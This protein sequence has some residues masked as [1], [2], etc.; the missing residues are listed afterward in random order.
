MLAPMALA[1]RL[2]V[3]TI[4]ARDVERLRRFYQDLGWRSP[5]SSDPDFARFETGGAVLTLYRMGALAEEA[6]QAEPPPGTFGGINCAVNV[7][8]PEEVDA[9]MEVVRRAGG[10][11]VAEPVTRHWGGRSGYFADPEGNVWEV[12]WLP[13]SAFDERGALIW[14]S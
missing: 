11:V 14:P 8:S 12:A 5:S 7:D 3:V 6:G 10:R 2:T 4:G 13:G 9:A 1:P